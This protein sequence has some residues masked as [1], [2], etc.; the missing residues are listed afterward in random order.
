MK[1]TA[2][3]LPLLFASAALGSTA[4]CGSCTASGQAYCYNTVTTGASNCFDT[5]SDCKQGCANTYGWR[6]F[7]GVLTGEQRLI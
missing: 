6:P 4:P 7:S 1:L 2:V 3:L 5:A